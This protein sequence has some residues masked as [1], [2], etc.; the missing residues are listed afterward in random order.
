MTLPLQAFTPPGNATKSP[1]ADSET[2][3][4]FQATDV[5]VLEEVC[6]LLESATMDV[7]DVRISLAR[8]LS[9]NEPPHC[10]SIMLNFIEKAEYPAEWV[11]SATNQ[12]ESAKM[13]RVVDLCKTAVIR[14]V[15]EVSGEDD[16][17]NVLWDVKQSEGIFVSRLLQW[18]KDARDSNSGSIRDDLVI[19]ATLCLGNL[20]RGGELLLSALL[21]KAHLSPQKHKRM[22]CQIL[23]SQLRHSSFLIS[24]QKQTSSSS[25]V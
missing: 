5:D 15:V 4:A 7:E 1:F 21:S 23:R 2:C 10:L 8:G 6:E 3:D 22:L 19:C 17:L 14:A 16:N 13:K 12:S 25:M 24:P 9:L 20:V 11:N 18:I